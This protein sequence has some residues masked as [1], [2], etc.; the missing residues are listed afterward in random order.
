MTDLDMDVPE[1]ETVFNTVQTIDYPTLVSLGLV[2]GHTANSSIG[3]NSAIPSS[4][5]ILLSNV[6]SVSF[7]FNFPAVPQQMQ[8]V[9]SSANDTA[10][11]TGAEQVKITY[12]RLPT[13]PQ[14]FTVNT[15]FINMA[16][17]A[18]V[19]TTNTDIYRIEK[20]EVSKTG[21]GLSSIGNISLQSVGGA[22]TFEL[23]P[24]E[25]NINRTCIHFVPKGFK[26]TLF[27]VSKGT[28][29]A[30]GVIFRVSKT[31]QYQGNNVVS[32]GVDQL[33]AAYFAVH[34]NIV[35]PFTI[36]NPNGFEMYFAIL[37]RGIASNQSASGAINFIDSPI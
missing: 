23:I 22:I 14:G 10:L 24:N 4:V 27:S 13:S 29:T 30:G 9:S 2:P 34:S 25:S 17:L 35:P 36:Q 19:L 21:T 20:I 8:V 37:V 12:L 26:S 11:G 31:F 5:S 16:G 28:S 33:E 6:T 3:V 7:P 18:A 32:H 15:E 1:P